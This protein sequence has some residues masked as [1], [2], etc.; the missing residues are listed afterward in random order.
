MIVAYALLLLLTLLC[1]VVICW[2]ILAA[3][4]HRRFKHFPGPPL[5]SFFLGNL[6]SFAKYRNEGKYVSLFLY[7]CHQEYGFTFRYVYEDYC[8]GLFLVDGNKPLCR[9]IAFELM[10]FMSFKTP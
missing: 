2:A 7:E 5:D 1:G 6:T 3:R 8:F 10:R 9:S 4:N